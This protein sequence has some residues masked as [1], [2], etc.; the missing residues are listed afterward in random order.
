MTINRIILMLWM[1]AALHSTGQA[2]SLGAESTAHRYNVVMLGDS[3]TWL[4][5]D[6]C[7]KE[8]GWSKWFRE[9]FKPATCVS[10]ARSGA[11]WTNTV[12]TKDNTTENS[13]VI[14]DDNVIYNQ[15]KRLRQAWKAGTQPAPDLIIILAGTN[16]AW[17]AKKRPG[18][19]T[20]TAAQAFADKSLTTATPPSKVLTLAKAVRHNVMILKT[21]FPNA[22]IVLLTP[23]Q[24]TSI[25]RDKITITGNIIEDCAKSLGVSVIRLD[26][27]KFID[28]QRE[29]THKEHTT[30][31]TH[32]NKEG[33]KLIGME[34]AA[35]IRNIIFT[36]NSKKH[37]KGK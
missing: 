35:K 9:A 20:M 37:H 27:N 34:V 4:G 36:D 3:N 14:T 13:G 15:V 28:P 26:P 18:A 21:L 19:L 31:G 23:M 33:A 22:R 1:L 30:D 8:N 11:T 2:Q 24:S 29:R 17:F 6:D 5:G 16:D 10:Y 7:S 12:R 32:T 25:S